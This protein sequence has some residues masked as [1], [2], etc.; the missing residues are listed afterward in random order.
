[1]QTLWTPL[2]LGGAM[3][4]FSSSTGPHTLSTDNNSSDGGVGL[5]MIQRAEVIMGTVRHLNG[6]AVGAAIIAGA[7]LGAAAPH[8]PTAWIAARRP[9][10]CVH[11]HGPASTL[12]PTS[13]TV[14]G[15]TTECAI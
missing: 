9:L 4:A 13:A 11:L 12:V 1:M 2:A 10:T 7:T 6:I 14:G 8:R 15:T 3:S 5:D